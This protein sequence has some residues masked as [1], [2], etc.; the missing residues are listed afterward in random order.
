[1]TIK[2]KCMLQLIFLFSQ[3]AVCFPW[4]GHQMVDAVQGLEV[5][6]YGTMI[7]PLLFIAYIVSLWKSSQPIKLC[8]YLYGIFFIN[9]VLSLV[10][11]YFK[12]HFITSVDFQFT[13]VLP[14]FYLYFIMAIIGCL[15]QLYYGHYNEINRVEKEG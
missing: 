4:F 15:L 5:M 8:S 12:Y 6:L 9:A 10:V 13:L 11:F 14:G 3:L 7:Y 1:M 2:A